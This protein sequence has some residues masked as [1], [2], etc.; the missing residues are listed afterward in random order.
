MVFFAP[1]GGRARWVGE[2]SGRDFAP[3]GAA[4][5]FLGG[6]WGSFRRFPGL[7]QVLFRDLGEQPFPNGR[8]PCAAGRS[9]RKLSATRELAR[10]M[11]LCRA[12]RRHEDGEPCGVRA[13]SA[14]YQC[15]VAHGPW[16][17]LSAAAEPAL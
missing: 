3:E 17:L 14:A 6:S 8:D 9:K 2:V 7:F 11:A 13:R 4:I 10:M 12:Q 1:F 15:L 5:A 16:W